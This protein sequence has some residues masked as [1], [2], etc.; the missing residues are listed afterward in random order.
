MRVEHDDVAVLKIW[1]TPHAWYDHTLETSFE[2]ELSDD[3]AKCI[4]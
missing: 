3:L 1:I 2:D 4:A